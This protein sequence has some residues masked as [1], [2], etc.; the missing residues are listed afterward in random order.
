MVSVLEG[1]YNVVPDKSQKPKA[2]KKSVMNSNFHH[3][4]KLHNR[5]VDSELLPYGSL[6]RSCASH[7][8]ALLNASHK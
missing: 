7:V 1:G 6:A 3:A 4:A 8:S 5:E 2:T